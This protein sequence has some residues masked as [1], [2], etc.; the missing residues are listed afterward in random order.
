[1]LLR[2]L[3][4]RIVLA[5]A[6]PGRTQQELLVINDRLIIDLE[7]AT[8][9]AFDSIKGLDWSSTYL[10]AFN[11]VTELDVSRKIVRTARVPAEVFGVLFVYSRDGRFA[12]ASLLMLFTVALVLIIDI[13]RPTGRGVFESQRAMEMLQKK[14]ASTTSDVDRWRTTHAPAPVQA[15]ERSP[16]I[17][18]P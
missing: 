3:D 5:K 7:A 8:A 14:L 4:N 6:P 16:Q 2:Y 17:V 13:D 9:A 10:D 12:A 15:F 1:L 11:R 18:A